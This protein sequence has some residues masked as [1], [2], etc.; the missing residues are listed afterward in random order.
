MALLPARVKYRKQHTRGWRLDHT[1]QTG[2]RLAFGD[3]GI[4][5][6][7]SGEL[8]A[9]QIEAAR[10]AAGHYLGRVGKVWIRAFPHHPVGKHPAE[11]RMG[12]GKG[13]VNYW[14]AFVDKGMV[15]FEF[16]GVTEDQARE[17]MRR[18][19]FKLPLK[20]RMIKRS[21]ADG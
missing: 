3:F 10:V 7:E 13:E 14:A 19:A 5:V 17:A 9:R 15:I 21:G 2:N 8:T 20:T 1:A 16:A 6:L 4:Q 12:S 18:Q 11:S